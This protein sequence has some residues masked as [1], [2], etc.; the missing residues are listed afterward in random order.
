MM[1]Q[2]FFI[3]TGIFWLAV[4]LIAM[5][6]W[7][8]PAPQPASNIAAERRISLTEV[9]R[10]TSEQDCWMAINGKVYDLSAYLPDHP[11]KPSV[12]LPWC[13]KEASQAYQTKNKGRSHSPQADQ[14]LAN[15]PIGLVD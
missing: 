5:N 14:L 15:Y 3:S 13:G 1:R 2:L 9:A 10:H 4:G 11:S 6:D 7:M 8:T 12:I